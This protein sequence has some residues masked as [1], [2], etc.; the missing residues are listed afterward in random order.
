MKQ[1]AVFG[2]PIA[3]SL[4]PQIHQAF[5]AQFGIALSYD[6]VEANI[7]QFDQRLSDFRNQ[8]GV[9]ANITLPLKQHALL[10]CVD[11]DSAARS[12]G[13]VNTLIRRGDVWH[14]ANTDGVGLIRDLT[15]RHS[16][17]L[18]GKRLLIIG[19]GGAARG[20]IASF[21]AAGVSEIVIANRTVTKAQ[22]LADQYHARALALAQLANEQAFDVI[23]HASSAGHQTTEFQMPNWPTSMAHGKSVLVELSYGKAAAP[24]LA[25]A[26]ELEI[27]AIDGLGMLIEQAAEAF[28]LWH[29]VRPNTAPVWGQLRAEI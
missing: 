8:G 29:G 12:A 22:D 25:F 21:Q 7:E 9:G 17:A 5:A 2:Q 16:I 26:S 6:R 18:A 15:N 13:A 27:Q 19:A 14:G 23:V 11:V 3:H 10:A 24:A 1:F 20:V 4:S 28:Y